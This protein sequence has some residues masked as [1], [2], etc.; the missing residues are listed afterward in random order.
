MADIA[1]RL[2]AALEGRYRI[3]GELGA[4]GMATVRLAQFWNWRYLAEHARLFDPLRD[5]PRFRA[6]VERAREGWL[7]LADPGTGGR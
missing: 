6:L 1:D 4:A 2:T 5:E 3:E 7:S